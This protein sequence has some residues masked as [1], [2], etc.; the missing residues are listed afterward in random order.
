M[1]ALAISTNRRYLAV[2]ECGEKAT[3]TVYDLQHEQSRKRKQLSGGEIPVE[4]FVCMTFSPDS[5]YLIGQAGGPDW[6]L[7]LWMWEKQKV[8]ATV[9]TSST[10]TITQVNSI[11]LYTYKCYLFLK[12]FFAVLQSCEAALAICIQNYIDLKNILKCRIH[13]INLLNNLYN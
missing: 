7:F 5:K 2:S 6:T 9:K 4:E 10:G 1:K 13:V 8:M 12:Y 3:I 11:T